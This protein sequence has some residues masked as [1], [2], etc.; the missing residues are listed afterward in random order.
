MTAKFDDTHIKCIAELQI[1]LEAAGVFGLKATIPRKERAK[2]IRDRLIRFK[3]HR[4]TKKEKRILRD[5]LCKVT[6]LKERTM[7]YHITAY[8]EGKKICAPYKRNRFSETYNNTDREL[9][10]ETDNLH[11]RLNGEATRKIFQA[12]YD[13]GDNRYERLKHISNGHLYNLRKSRIY[14][15]R[16]LNLAKTQSVQRNIGERAKPKPD[17]QPGFIRVDTVHQGDQNGEKGVYHIN[18]VDE[19]TQWEIVLAVPEISEKFLEPVLQEALQ[20][21][22]FTI[23]NF[24]S[25]NGSEYINQVVAKLLNTLLIRQTKSRPRRSNDNGLVESKN[26]SIIRKHMGYWHI[27]KKWAARINGFY[28]DHLIPYINY[29]RPCAFPTE[30]ILPNGKKKISYRDYMPPLAKLLSIK[31]VTQ[32][33]KSGITIESLKKEVAKRNPNQA[34]E[35]MQKAKK[36][37]FKMIDDDLSGRTK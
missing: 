37:L 16:S 7:K 2:W 31:D 27:P 18:L 36:N 8:K 35:E 24:H 32:Y 23:Q 10:V 26:A 34:A 1:F 12:M 15:E 19:V 28:R 13:A 20:L 33:L 5:Y 17:G 22:P 14:C 25:D 21:F 30:E 11:Q 3:Y 29:Y 4:L 6:G 9:L